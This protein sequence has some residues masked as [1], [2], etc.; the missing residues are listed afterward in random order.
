LDVAV[1]APATDESAQR[2]QSD[3]LVSAIQKM[4]MDRKAPISP[5]LIAVEA[6]VGG[7][8]LALFYQTTSVLVSVISAG[9]S[10][11]AL[12]WAI[13]SLLLVVLPLGVGLALSIAI[14]GM[15]SN[16]WAA[17]RSSRRSAVAVAGGGALAAA[18][19]LICP[20]AV[21]GQGLDAVVAFVVTAL[22]WLAQYRYFVRRA[23]I[24]TEGR[25]GAR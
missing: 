5:R 20:R 8:A 21:A 2:S 14:G 25:T 24:G 12:A 15:L 19:V 4:A 3:N 9:G 23:A 10:D 22:F 1:S 11:V 18:L 13:P 7:L 16:E 6:I 17:H